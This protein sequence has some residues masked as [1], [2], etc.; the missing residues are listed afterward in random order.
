MW[1]KIAEINYD[2]FFV[3]VYYFVDEAWRQSVDFSIFYL[4]NQIQF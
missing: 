2:V 1:M 4:A 3:I